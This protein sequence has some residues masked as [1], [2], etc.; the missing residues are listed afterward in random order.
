MGMK[1]GMPWRSAMKSIY[2]RVV[3]TISLALSLIFTTSV[4]YG[5]PG[6]AGRGGGSMSNGFGRGDRI[7]DRGGSGGRMDRSGGMGFRDRGSGQPLGQNRDRSLTFRD[8]NWNRSNWDRDGDHDRDR[9][10]HRFFFDFGLGF[11]DPFFYDFYGYGPY[12]YYG[13]PYYG[14][15]YYAYP[16]DYYGRP[17]YAP[18]PMKLTP[19]VTAQWVEPNTLKV[20]WIGRTGGFSRLEV[21]LLDADGRTLKHRTGDLS[22]KVDVPDRAVDVRIR[23]LDPNQVILS[24]T[25]VPLPAR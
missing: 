24:E 7:G 8:R 12:G 19:D 21:A 16:Y 20:T 15:P 2:M 3:A 1:Y 25:V 11:G 10:R 5:M 4:A 6:F 9:F 18:A 13:Y 23:T 22:I 14:S 17:Y